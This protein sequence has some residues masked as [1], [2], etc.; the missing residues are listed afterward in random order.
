MPRDPTT[1][2]RGTA[3]AG[4]FVRAGSERGEPE[5]ALSRGRTD[6]AALGA[7]SAGSAGSAGSPSG[8][9]PLPLSAAP[10]PAGGAA[11]HG[12]THPVT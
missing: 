9:A 2:H 12:N 6:P 8:S 10:G 7:P 1:C 3:H 5:A 4:A 11:A